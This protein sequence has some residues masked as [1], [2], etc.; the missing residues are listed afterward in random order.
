MKNFTNTCRFRVPKSFPAVIL[1]LLL[2]NSC[3]KDDGVMEYQNLCI[4]SLRIITSNIP[5]SLYIDLTFV[6]EN[7]GYSVSNNG[8]IVKTTDGGYNW[9]QLSSPV[10]FFLNRIQ[11]TD[12]QTGY[13]TGGNN[14][15]GYLLKTTDAGQTWEVNNLNTPENNRP[16]GMF[17]LNHTT[18]YISGDKLF[19]KTTD[20][21]K[22]WAEV[23]SSFS[24]NTE[25]RLPRFW[26]PRRVSGTAATILI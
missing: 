12:S 21:G 2:I 19:R 3:E 5:G 13:I 7:V 9:V 6:D 26:Q 18:G 1:I 11:F 24:E 4:D 22:T 14:T 20:G 23:F 25:S 15:G 8:M 10:T 16:E 17:F